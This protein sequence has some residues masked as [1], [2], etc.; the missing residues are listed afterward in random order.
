M[1]TV[2]EIPLFVAISVVHD[3]IYIY[4]L[5]D[6][7]K[8]RYHIYLGDKSDVESIIAFDGCQILFVSNNKFYLRN[9]KGIIEECTYENQ[10]LPWSFN[11]Y[12]TV[13]NNTCV[14]PTQIL[15]KPLYKKSIDLGHKYVID[16]CARLI[17]SISSLKHN[18]MT[19]EEIRVLQC[20]L[21]GDNFEFIYKSR[22]YYYA[23]RF[24]Y[25]LSIFRHVKS[26]IKL[27]W[28]F[29]DPSLRKK[30]TQYGQVRR[31][32]VLDVPKNHERW[33]EF[34]EQ[35]FGYLGLYLNRNL[36]NIIAGYI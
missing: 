35:I 7:I 32:M 2:L 10:Q 18:V 3:G 8:L 27:I 25:S 5:S 34:Q 30:M 19:D 9:V 33:R 20:M 1:E 36:S 23:S 16:D 11:I 31:M 24:N 15:S 22:G 14:I 29:D 13:E 28:K 21:G 12:E 6:D 17:K 26:D 4:D